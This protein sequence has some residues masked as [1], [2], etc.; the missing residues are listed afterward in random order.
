M[1][2]LQHLKTIFQRAQTARNAPKIVFMSYCMELLH[3]Y[4]QTKGKEASN[5]RSGFKR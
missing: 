1:R 4:A 3:L 2:Y 5:A